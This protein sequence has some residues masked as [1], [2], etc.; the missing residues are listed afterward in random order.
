MR[1]QAT[2]AYGLPTIG[3]VNETFREMPTNPKSFIGQRYFPAV[4]SQ[5]DGQMVRWGVYREASGMTYA[6]VYS[7]DPRRVEGTPV[8]AFTVCAQPYKESYYLGEEELLMLGKLEDDRQR[9]TAADLM[10]GL[11]FKAHLRRQIRVEHEIWKAM[12]DGKLVVQERGIDREV[13]FQVPS[14]NRINADVAWDQP[15]SAKPLK[16]LL[17]LIDVFEDLDHDGIDLLMNR[18]TAK[19]LVEN[20]DIADRIAGLPDS[21]RRNVENIGALIMDLLG[22]VDRVEVYNR[23]YKDESSGLRVRFIPDDIVCAIAKPNNASSEGS[24]SVGEFV[25][26]ESIHGGSLEDPRPGPFA[27]PNYDH[28]KPEDGNPHVEMIAGVYGLACLKQPSYVA[29]L[30]TKP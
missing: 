11:M 4:N 5:F 21:K 7:T 9:A 14:A 13:D 3:G 27:I 30:N 2:L 19:Y 17:K 25:M 28:A 8:A 10:A 24:T 6:H 16:D 1:G 26:T 29:T 23:G 12:I 22:E 20:E 18:N 15:A